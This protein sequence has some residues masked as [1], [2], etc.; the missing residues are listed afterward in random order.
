[1]SQDITEH[2]KNLTK[3]NE[4]ENIT[5]LACVWI[6]VDGTI[7]SSWSDLD[8]TLKSSLTIAGL[9]YTKAKL[10]WS[11]MNAENNAAS[12]EEPTAE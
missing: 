7:H 12:K 4:S 9:E 3:E 6:T 11:L 2:L 8:T 5:S 10:L 1:M